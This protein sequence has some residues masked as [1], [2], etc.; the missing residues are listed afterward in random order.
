MRREAAGY[1]TR[2]RDAETERDQLRAR[3][4]RHE[5]ADVER[6]AEAAGFAQSSDIFMFAGDLEQLRDQGGELDTGRLQE[7]ARRVLT[8]RPGLRKPG[9]DFGSGS[10]LDNGRQQPT[11]LFDLLRQHQARQPGPTVGGDR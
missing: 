5:R 11:G 2:L 3:V 6:L 1:R 4:E 8:E 7:L 9:L 10:R